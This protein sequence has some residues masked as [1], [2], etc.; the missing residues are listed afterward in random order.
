MVLVEPIS[1]NLSDPN[2]LQLV[3]FD[4]HYL[5]IISFS[6]TKF[7]RI[8]NRALISLCDIWTTQ[9]TYSTKKQANIVQKCVGQIEK[10]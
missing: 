3:Y 7:R 10:V 4:V 6:K 2:D 8:V 5:Q 1:P 9:Q